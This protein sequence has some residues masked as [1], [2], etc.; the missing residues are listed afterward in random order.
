VTALVAHLI[1]GLGTGGA[2]RQ[3]AR[4]AATGGGE[5]TH[6]VISMTDL[7]PVGEQMR[8]AG[9][10][11][12]ALGMRRGRISPSGVGRLVGLL[13]RSRPVLL[14]TW[15]YHADL[16]GVLAAPLAGVGTVVWNL[17][18]SDMD[19]ARYSRLSALVVR[20]SARLSG[21]PAAVVH[22]SQAGRRAHERLGYHPRRWQYIANGFD[23]EDFRP[24][25]E[26][27]SHVRSELGIGAD[28][29]LVGLMARY[30]PMKDHATFLSAASRLAAHDPTVH[31]VL[32]GA[33][34][35]PGNADLERQIATEG[36]QGKVSLLGRRDDM[37]RLCA[38][39]DL[40]VSSSAFGEG[41]PNSLGEALAC[42]V[43]CVA[44]DVGD[45]AEIIAEAGRTVPARDP[46][47]LADAMA[48]MLAMPSDQREALGRQARARVAQDYGIAAIV[49][50]Y[51]ALYGDLL[52]KE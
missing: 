6:M 13:R 24:D 50:R 15:L 48:E 33:G 28:A 47:A 26:A 23:T 32:A 40:A 8:R 35:E 31:F 38:G 22:N 20:L 5:F 2:E 43:C 18:C 45:A 19:F 36:L 4:L 10:E 37:P 16:L 17:R 3:L 30:D 29:P 11:V 34:V 7:G 39:L 51:A 52:S 25:P 21:L 44:T 42:G 49:G 1:T 9:I 41:F 14:Q 46:A 12:H 27:R